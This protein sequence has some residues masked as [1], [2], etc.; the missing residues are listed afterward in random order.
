[1]V[2]VRLGI[3]MEPCDG[4]LDGTPEGYAISI[5]VDDGIPQGGVRKGEGVNA[6]PFNQRLRQFR[7]LYLRVRHS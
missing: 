7:D 4:V 2:S 1:M 6:M 3:R 5:T